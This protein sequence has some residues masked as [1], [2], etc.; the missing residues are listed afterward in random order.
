MDYNQYNNGQ[1]NRNQNYYGQ[2]TPRKKNNG[3]AIASMVCGICSVVLSC[4]GLSLPFGALGIL[5]AILTCRKGRATDS[6][7]IAG[8]VTSC[9]GLFM[10]VLMIIS[11][12]VQL[13]SMLQDQTFRKE[14]DTVYEAIYGED[15]AE[16]WENN[17]G[18]EIE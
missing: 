7:S 14:L 5:F 3:F 17:Y 4:L 13:P 6:M 16:F 2:P 1:N 11:V 18:I 10:S 15:F 8:I 9:I 12:F